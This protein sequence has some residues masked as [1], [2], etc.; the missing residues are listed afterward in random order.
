MGMQRMQ[1]W[2]VDH[3]VLL[4]AKLAGLKAGL[5]LTQDQEELW[6]PFEAAVRDGA[7]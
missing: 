2:A 1:R 7:A 5:K 3:Q 4:D 6:V